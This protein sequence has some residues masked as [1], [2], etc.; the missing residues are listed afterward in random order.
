MTRDE[1]L[2]DL[3]KLDLELYS[4]RVQTFF[5]TQDDGTRKRFV[6]IREQVGMRVEQLTNAQLKEIANKLE[7][8]SKELTAGI[9]ALNESI[10]QLNDA[11]AVLHALDSVVGLVGQVVAHV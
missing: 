2:A 1:L 10:G 11:V 8:L 9:E 7:S 4:P 3:R 5:E 6:Q